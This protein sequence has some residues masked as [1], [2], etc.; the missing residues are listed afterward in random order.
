M[1]RHFLGPGSK[2]PKPLLY[3]PTQVDNRKDTATLHHQVQ[4]SKHTTNQGKSA[5]L[6]HYSLVPWCLLLVCLSVLECV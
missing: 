6:C 2:P 1:G 4:D 3:P 5:P